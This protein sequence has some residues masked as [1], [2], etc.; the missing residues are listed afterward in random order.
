MIRLPILAAGLCLAIYLLLTPGKA[1]ANVTCSLTGQTISFG[2]A[3]S[4]TG[5]IGYSCT[6][7]N[8]TSTSLTLCSQLGSPS[9][10]GTTAQPKMIDSNNNP[11]SFNLYTDA[12]RST[13]WVGATVL[14]KPITIPASG[15]V[16]GSLPFYGAIPPGQGAVAGSYAGYFYATS[17]GMVNAGSCAQNVASVFDGMNNTLTATATVINACTVATSNLA[18]GS[19][20]ATSTAIAGSATLSVTCPKDT[21][22]YIGLAPSNGSTTGAGTLAGAGSN[23]DRPAYQLRSA[24]GSSGAIWGNTATSSS[25]GNGVAGTGTG[26]AQN[27]TVYVTMP[28]AN[29]RPDTYSD[30]VTV[31]VNY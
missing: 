20:A 2:T 12:G 11:L 18:L 28:S 30:T 3:N 8:D 29:Y 7:Y 5:S 9:Y 31:T 26:A 13:V 16:T 24:S 4:G 22:Y 23:S 19:V 1:Q 27:R 21:A 17:L 25:V 6:S 14:S 10:P 15:T